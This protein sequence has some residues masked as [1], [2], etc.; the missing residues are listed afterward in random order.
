MAAFNEMTVS[1]VSIFSLPPGAILSAFLHN[2]RFLP[3]TI[4]VDSGCASEVL[5]HSYKKVRG[6]FRA[7]F[8]PNS[9]PRF[10]CLRAFFE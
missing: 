8:R 9:R 1:E 10:S 3:N 6:I 4:L 5:T 7:I 2:E